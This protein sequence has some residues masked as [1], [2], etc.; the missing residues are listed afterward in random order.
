MN[1]TAELNLRYS[2]QFWVL[3]IK[4]NPAHCGRARGPAA[5]EGAG[6]HP[7]ETQ[8]NTEWSSNSRVFREGQ[9]NFVLYSVPESR[10]HKQVNFSSM[11]KRT[12]SS[13]YGMG[14]VVRPRCQARQRVSGCVNG[15]SETHSLGLLCNYRKDC[16]KK[17]NIIKRRGAQESFF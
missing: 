1:Q 2:N 14:S 5:R 17:A 16:W 3:D 4:T 7:S 13:N 8:E 15:R 6:N 9:E 10:S 11:W 12:C